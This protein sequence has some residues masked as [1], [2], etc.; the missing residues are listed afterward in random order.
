MLANMH[1]PLVEGNFCDEHGNA[2][3]QTSW[4]ITTATW[5]MLTRV[6]EWQIAFP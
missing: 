3:K 4:K 6:T 1:T 2:L 5:G